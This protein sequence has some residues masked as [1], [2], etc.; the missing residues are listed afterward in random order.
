METI[1]TKL[2]L[3]GSKKKC[4]RT[5]SVFLHISEVCDSTVSL[6]KLDVLPL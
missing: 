1:F 6:D 2:A 5:D 4:A 3:Y